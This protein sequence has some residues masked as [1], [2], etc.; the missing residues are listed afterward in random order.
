MK[1]KRTIV[2]PAL[3]ALVAFVSGGWLL[4]QGVQE[5]QR[6]AERAAIFQEILQHV[7][8]RYVDETSTSELYDMAIDGLLEKIGDPHTSLMTA[9]QYDNLRVQTEGEYGG[10]GIEIGMRDGWVTVISPLPDSPAERAGIRA[11][12]RIVEVE[13]ESTEGWGVDDAVAVLRGPRGE[14]A[15]IRIARPGADD[16]IA[17][18]VVRDDIEY[19]ALQAQHMLEGNIGYVRLGVFSES[20]TREIRGAIDDL[21]TEGAERLIL[22]LRTNPGGLLEQG[23]SVSDIFLPRG[24]DIVETRARDPRQNHTFRASRDDDYADLPMVILVDQSSA[25]ASEIVAGA[26]QDHDRAVVVGTPTFGKGSV[27]TLY[28]L[29]GGN[30]L[31]MTTGRWY[32]P[33]GRSIEKAPEDARMEDPMALMEDDEGEQSDVPPPEALLE[34]DDVPGDED[35]VPAEEIIDTTDRQP[36]RTD[37][38][39]VVFGGGGIVPDVIVRDVL[40]EAEQDFFRASLRAE[41]LPENLFFRYATEYLQRNP[42]ATWDAEVT[43]EMRSE[44]VALFRAEGVDLTDEQFEAA[45]RYIDHQIGSQIAYQTGGRAAAQERAAQTDAV[46][47]AAVELLSGATDRASLFAAAAERSGTARN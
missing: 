21:R 41:Q 23:V 43:P 16:S 8:E 44:T 27:Q 30:F 11:G 9:E 24:D 4:Q 13:G 37:S 15:S 10:L 38:G 25:S 33:V 45:G 35:P 3:V 12:D 1:L 20:A 46:V 14:A 26:L 31:K 18:E 29:S 17:L 36:Y 5:E 47:R 19:A 39:R 7:S 34:D 22:D 28:P 6:T 32:T 42:D 40:T 2:A